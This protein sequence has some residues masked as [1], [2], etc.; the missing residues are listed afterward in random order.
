[1]GQMVLEHNNRNFMP[2]GPQARRR[3]KEK[4]KPDFSLFLPP[5]AETIVFALIATHN[6]S[7]RALRYKHST[8]LG[9]DENKNED[10]KYLEGIPFLLILQHYNHRNTR[11][12]ETTLP[13][14]R[15]GQATIRGHCNERCRHGGGLSADVHAGRVQA[16]EEWAMM[17]HA[18]GA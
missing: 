18:T 12:M 3:R 1:M 7:V 15:S 5:D 6:Q 14:S 17:V 2:S 11:E 8:H 10:E 13:D 16:A 9:E 4:G